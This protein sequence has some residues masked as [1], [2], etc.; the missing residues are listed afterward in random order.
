[1][2]FVAAATLV[3]AAGGCMPAQGSSPSP[4]P[5]KSAPS[6]V[7]DGRDADVVESV[8]RALLRQVNDARARLGQ[9]ALL[10][11]PALQRAATRYSAELARRGVL[12]HES[13][14][15]G[16]RTFI[17]RLVAEGAKRR[18]A[19]ENLAALTES[20]DAVAT[21]VVRLWLESPYHRAN[22]LEPT[23]TRTG[24]GVSAGRDGVWYVAEE[25]ATAD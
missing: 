11:D 8:S 18:G 23:F 10:R 16:R 21:Q 19:G 5:M 3:L 12:D 9:Q 2:K 24:I 22:L 7:V 20:P 4:L 15:P 17:A 1:M 25:Y 6:A 13:P 14:V